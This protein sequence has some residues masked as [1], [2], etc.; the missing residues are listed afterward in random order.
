[1]ATLFGGAIGANVARMWRDWRENRKFGNFAILILPN[2][3]KPGLPP[4]LRSFVNN[5]FPRSGVQV[6]PIFNSEQLPVIVR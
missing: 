6:P 1:M 2:S 3:L 4:A 5:D